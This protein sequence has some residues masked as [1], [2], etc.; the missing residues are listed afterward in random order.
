MTFSLKQALGAKALSELLEMH[1]KW[2]GGLPPME[3][4]ALIDALKAKML[5]PPTVAAIQATLAPNPGAAFFVL[6]GGPKSG[7]TFP[8]IHGGLRGSGIRSGGLRAALAELFAL[9]FSAPVGEEDSNGN[10]R[11]VIPTELRKALGEAIPAQLKTQELLTLHGFLEQHFRSQGEGDKAPES[12]RRMYR[13]LASEAALCGRIEELEAETREVVEWAIVEWGGL[14]PLTELVRKG[15]QGPKLIQLRKVLEEETIGTIA[16]FDLECYGIRQR[17]PIM[18]IFNEAVLAWLK[19]SAESKEIVPCDVASIGVDF[20]SNFSR[21]A[22]FVGDETIRFTVRGAIFKSTEK[23][24]A[25]QLIPNPGKEFRRREILELEYRF[26][27]AYRLIDRTGE[28][29]FLMTPAGKEFLEK[30]L[31]AKQVMMLDWLIEDR[32][33]PGDMAHQLPLRRTALRYIKRM[34]PGRWYEAMFLPFVAR[35]HYLVEQ[36]IEREGSF[37]D[38]PFP[39]RSSADLQ[40]LSWNLFNWIRKHLY[41]LG[42]VDM[43]YEKTGRASAIRLT[44]LGAELLEMIPGRHLEGAGHI[45][46]NPDFEV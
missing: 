20:V 41:I 40:S 46:V 44:K 6:L 23:R 37:D 29:S 19:C 38:A 36:A 31:H 24:I 42:I 16:E 33:L 11:W 26:A 1:E 10:P 2:I 28:R 22:S 30:D 3:R 7:L 15:I 32:E 27:L 18:A 21:F 12:A 9:G 4:L 34:E 17:G 14:V 5:D 39:V 43:G 25:E 8:K 35:N 45:V 13:F